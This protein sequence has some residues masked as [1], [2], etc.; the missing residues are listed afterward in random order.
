MK[1]LKKI[2]KPII[3]IVVIL[4]L[5]LTIFNFRFYIMKLSGL[6]NE[7]IE[8]K[9][10]NLTS[11]K[12]DDFTFE[13]EYTIKVNKK[14]KGIKLNLTQ[15]NNNKEIKITPKFKDEG[16]KYT[17]KELEQFEYISKYKNREYI[18]LNSQNN[19]TELQFQMESKGNFHIESIEINTW[20]F[21]FNWFRVCSLIL[22]TL[23]I[24]YRKEINNYFEKNPNNKKKVYIGFIAISTIFFIYYSYGFGKAYENY[25]WD[26]GMVLKDMYRELTQSIMQGKITLDFPE[27]DKQELSNLQNYQDYSERIE[28]GNTYLYDAAFYKGNYYCYYGI[29]PV[30]TILLPIALVT[31]IYCYS[32]VICIVYG[33]LVMILVL[34]IYLKLLEKFK[35]KFGFILEFIGY[36]TLVLTMELFILKFE[37]NFYQAVDLCGIFWVLFAVWQIWS[38]ENKEKIK[39][40]LFLIGVSY[41]CMVLTRPLYVFYIIPIIIA[42]WKNLLQNKKIE[43]KNLA[44]FAFPIVIMAIFQMWY[45]HVRFENILEFGQFRQITVNDTSSLELEPGLAID[46][47]LS[48]LFNPPTLIRHFPFMGY[49]NAGVRNGNEILAMDIFGIFWHPFMVILITARKR[50]KNNNKNKELCI[51]TIVFWLISI[52]LFSLNT[53]WGG[54]HQRYLSDVLPALTILSLIYWLLFIKESKNKEVKKERINIYKTVCISSIIIMSLYAFIKIDNFMFKTGEDTQIDKRVIEYN[55]KHSLEFY[56]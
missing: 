42:I 24:M 7:V 48:F 38:L 44:V 2:P 17:F 13:K 8:L 55:I 37:P 41:G 51:Y 40:K 1:M 35:V 3:A 43:W 4:L 33:T 49:S 14:I 27:E 26:R 20:Y 47:V 32:N 56:K 15:N 30:A 36:L 12:Y 50:I 10:E 23:F 6:E 39:R 52:V 18:V 46:G 16:Q 54:M 31:G 29:I 22:I 5:E 9:R 45:N 21:E 19:C 53:C 34:K 25:S 28:E 11:Y